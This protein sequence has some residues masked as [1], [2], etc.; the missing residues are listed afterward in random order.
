MR[1]CLINT[2]GIHIMEAGIDVEMYI[3]WTTEHLEKDIDVE[4]IL[5]N[6]I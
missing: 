4:Y 5:E 2:D 1:D 3:P 6:L